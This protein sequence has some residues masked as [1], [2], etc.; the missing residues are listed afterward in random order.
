MAKTNR[1]NRDLTGSYLYADGTLV[2]CFDEKRN[3]SKIGETVDVTYG[4]CKVNIY[5]RDQENHFARPVE[6]GRIV[7]HRYSDNAFVPLAKGGRVLAKTANL[8][9]GSEKTR[10]MGLAVQY[11]ELTM[12][13]GLNLGWSDIPG[14]LGSTF[15]V[16]SGSEY[17]EISQD[18]KPGDKW[19]FVSVVN[20]VVNLRKE[21]AAA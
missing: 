20:K 15:T 10:E 4:Y 13:N 16:Q 1:I 11:V 7:I 18:L 2:Q 8:K 6:Q 12:K 21:A 3:G 9:S 17:G 14:V 19:G 5:D